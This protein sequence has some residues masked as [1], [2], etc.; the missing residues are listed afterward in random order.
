MVLNT[1]VEVLLR[2]GNV[3]SGLGSLFLSA[4]LVWLYRKQHIS[5]DQQRELLERQRSEELR[6]D[7]SDVLRDRIS[8]WLGDDADLE[9][10]IDNVIDGTDV[11][12]PYVKNAS[13]EPAT[14]G[15][16]VTEDFNTIPRE[17]EDDRY[18][19]DFLENHDPEVDNLCEE[20]E[21]LQSEYDSIRQEF[22][23]KY[24][25]LLPLEESD[26]EIHPGPEF[27]TWA[28]ER[29]VMLERGIC[30]REE[31]K[32][33]VDS[34]MAERTSGTFP[35]DHVTEH[36]QAVLS[37]DPDL[38]LDN[39]AGIEILNTLIDRLNS[40]DYYEL[41]VEGAEILEQIDD[42]CDELHEKLIIYEGLPIYPGDCQYVSY[43]REE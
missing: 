6:K 34:A 43:H 32:D 4:A 1:A 37:F 26:H 14:S 10:S 9:P 39:S 29:I 31:L 2:W 20:I 30:D 41:G 25:D 15:L 13:V 16:Y 21:D 28:F 11:R 40:L 36:G 3:I 18:L 27:G 38:R 24:D 7:H 42:K 8:Y 35:G 5:L 23:A 22:S 19:R 33:R 12:Y 17:I